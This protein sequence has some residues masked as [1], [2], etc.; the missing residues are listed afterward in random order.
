MIRGARSRAVE[1]RNWAVLA[2]LGLASAC[3][4]RPPVD[5]QG[6][7]AS[8]AT[9]Q[10]LAP[11]SGLAQARAEAD[12]EPEPEPTPP[13]PEPAQPEPEPL[14]EDYLQFSAA[15]AEGPRFTV[16]FGGDLLLHR[17]LQR[18]AYDAKD[19]AGA[20]VLWANIADLLAEPE[21]TYLNLEGPLAAGLD[22]DFVEVEDPGRSYD[23][24]VYSGYPRFNY[25]RSV[26][27]DLVRAGI[28][29]VSTANNHAL[30][31]GP[32]GVDRTVEA[33]ERARLRF[34]G[35]RAAEGPERWHAITRVGDLS[36]AWI[37]CTK[38][39]N[40]I[41]DPNG[42][43]LRCGD[44][45]AVRKTIERLLGRGR[46]AK[47]KPKVDAVIVTPH[48]GKEYSHFPREREQ[49]IAREWIE[50]GATAVIA[51]HPHVIQPWEKVEASDGREGL[52]FH[53]LGNFASHQP[54]LS[55]RSSVLL[56]LTFVVD[57]SSVELG[58]TA[59]AA[60]APS[61]R[62]RIAGARYLPLHV[63]Q[64]GKRF[65][66]EAI[67]R[68]EGPADARGLL[69]ALLGEANLVAPEGDK[70]GDPHCDPSWRP[71][72][73]PAWAQLDEP[74]LIPGSPEAE[75]AAAAAEAAAAEA[76]TTKSAG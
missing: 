54:E 3:P 44:G 52:I 71:A 46:Y 32:L 4:A 58:E 70:R 34:T 18:Q 75:A 45:A 14:P 31:R 16:A 24:V 64:D 15:C 6:G 11:S 74:I 25:H 73:T 2:V 13:E 17:E 5:S 20:E 27:K 9:E 35:T 50:A 28:D 29:V 47:R 42:Q 66:V 63:R 41:E 57:E 48:W 1:P 49:R 72:A 30:D 12:A 19:K 38:H 40:Q 37:A 7:V 10:P 51:S 61:P 8:G 69:V 39:T 43:V 36:L 65:F 59:E 53:S 26:A 23:G 76:A 55:R 67:D 68:V 60:A 33:L 56:Y 21:L 62:L 22:R